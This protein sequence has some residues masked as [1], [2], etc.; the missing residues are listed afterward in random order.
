MKGYWLFRISRGGTVVINY[1]KINLIEVASDVSKKCTSRHVP[2]ES[3]ISFGC[4][5]ILTLCRAAMN[6]SWILP[7]FSSP[8]KKGLSP[9]CDFVLFSVPQ[10][11][12]IAA[13]RLFWLTLVPRPRDYHVRG[14][15]A[16]QPSPSTQLENRL[17]AHE[18]GLVFASPM[19]YEC[20]LF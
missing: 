17:N 3:V 18:L 19:L 4:S 14:L 16:C 12:Q 5:H 15:S 1:G 20:T 7:G 13:I 11:A 6:T 9:V 10:I 2:K 8:M